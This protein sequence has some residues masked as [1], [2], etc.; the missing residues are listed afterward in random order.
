MSSMLSNPGFWVAVILPFSG[1]VML[2]SSRM[3][4]KK[5]IRLIDKL[6]SV[7]ERPGINAADIAIVETIMAAYKSRRGWVAIPLAPLVSFA[8]IPF[9]LYRLVFKGPD[10][11]FDWAVNFEDR[12]VAAEVAHL[13]N[14]DATKATIWKTKERRDLWRETSSSMQYETPLSHIWLA[15]W[16][17]PPLLII[18]ALMVV[19]GHKP[20]GARNA[21]RFVMRRAS[22]VE[23]AM[24]A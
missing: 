17:I 23:S 13:T 14:F 16:I 8:L 21:F 19:L 15:I 2:V 1:L 12:S 18:V 7:M 6:V 5:R 20:K 4:S 11:V 3:A 9:G 22:D 24:Q 10:Y